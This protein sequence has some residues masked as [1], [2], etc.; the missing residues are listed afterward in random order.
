MK[1]EKNTSTTQ[2]SEKCGYLKHS[3]GTWCVNPKPCEWHNKSPQ[4][5]WETKKCICKCH[6]SFMD[7]LEHETKCCEGMNGWLE[8]K[9]D[10]AEIK[11]LRK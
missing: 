9:F 5:D 1:K 7:G 3:D 4:E 11:K 8:K 2:D 10:P 6:D